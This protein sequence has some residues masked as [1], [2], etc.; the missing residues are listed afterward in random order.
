MLS[1][2]RPL[3]I[4]LRS[5][6]TDQIYVP[7]HNFTWRF[8]RIRWSPEEIFADEACERGPVLAVASPR[9]RLTSIGAGKI[10]VADSHWQSV[11]QELCAHAVLIVLRVGHTEGVQWELNML[12]EKIDAEIKFVIL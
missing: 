1:S 9:N 12:S 5:F 10:Y 7:P 3:I 11:V 2:N 8:F 6:S 4:Y